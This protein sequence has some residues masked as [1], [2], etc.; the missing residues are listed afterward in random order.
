MRAAGAGN[1]K[2]KGLGRFPG[3]GTLSRELLALATPSA[4]E[5]DRQAVDDDIQKAADNESDDE[6]KNRKDDGIVEV[7]LNDI[8]GLF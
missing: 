6:Y 7:G 1:D 4:I 2:I 5:H 3:V 8:H